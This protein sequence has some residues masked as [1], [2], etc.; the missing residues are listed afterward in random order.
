MKGPQQEAF[1]CKGP[2]PPRTPSPS[3]RHGRSH[4]GRP[5]TTRSHRDGLRGLRGAHMCSPPA[6][7][8]LYRPA[9]FWAALGE[10][11]KLQI[12]LFPRDKAK[13]WSGCPLPSP[14]CQEGVSAV[15]WPAVPRAGPDSHETA[16]S[17]PSPSAQRPAPCAGV[18]TGLPWSCIPPGLESASHGPKTGRFPAVSVWGTFLLP[19]LLPRGRGSRQICPASTEPSQSH[20]CARCFPGA[21][22][23]SAVTR[24]NHCKV[25]PAA[26]GCLTDSS[27]SSC[28]PN[29]S[30]K[31]WLFL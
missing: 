7:P 3:L 17:H 31:K 23:G 15:G 8:P 16:T 12:G 19:Q 5:T 27:R 6:C 25:F 30:L 28:D 2:P 21:G 26:Q 14:A 20:G 18:A 1:D 24:E 9:L 13:G 29:T 10:R 11:C 4:A 22:S